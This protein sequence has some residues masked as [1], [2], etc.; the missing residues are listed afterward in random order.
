MAQ[1]ASY[2]PQCGAKLEPGSNYCYNCGRP[3]PLAAAE[4]AEARP[5]AA[6]DM[7]QKKRKTPQEQKDQ[8]ISLAYY[9][10][11]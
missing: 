10:Y 7:T 1:V 8:F 5:P 4:K 3:T 9:A 6:K 11:G 2:C